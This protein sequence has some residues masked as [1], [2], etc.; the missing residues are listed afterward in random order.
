MSRTSKTIATAASTLA[1]AGMLL[2]SLPVKAAV[3]TNCD[4]T[5]ITKAANCAKG[6]GATGNLGTVISIV[7]NV[8]FGLVGSLA[9]LFLI[10][11]GISYITS[12]GDPK[13][14]A[15][16]KDT[17]LYAVIGIVVVLVSYAL[18]SFVISQFLMK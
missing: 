13:K 7:S 3:Q 14:T 4:L 16:A 12:Q 1:G 18:A 5:D 15:T 8:A 9:V 2:V 6:T 17:I 10:M 11:G